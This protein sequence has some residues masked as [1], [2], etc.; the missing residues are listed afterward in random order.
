MTRLICCALLS[1]LL[2]TGCRL[3][4]QVEVAVDGDGGGTLAVHLTADEQLRA[5]AADAGADPLETLEQ[6]AHGLEGWQ[7]TRSEDGGGTLT[8]STSFDDATELE[9]LSAEFADGLAAPE[10]SPLGPM[11]LT[12]TDDVVELDGTAGLRLSAAVAELG[13]TPARARARLADGLRYRVTARMPGAVLRTNADDRP[14][15][16]TA[17]WT[18]VPGER[19]ALKVTAER[20]WTLARLTAYLVESQSLTVLLAGAML[21]VAARRRDGLTLGAPTI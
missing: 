5:A 7:V 12:V 6:A 20:P 21:A 13:L 14:D 4:A 10:V 18:I 3:D 19:R 15:D 16:R 8:L 9:R 1:M 2:L 11:R 17:V